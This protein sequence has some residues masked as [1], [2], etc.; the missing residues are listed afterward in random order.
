VEK[1]KIFHFHNG[2]GGGV[3]SVIRNLLLYRQ[4]TEIENHVIYTINKEQVFLY[5]KPMLQ[6]ATSEQIFYYSPQWNFYYTCRQLAK[7]IPDDKAVI[8]AHDW[9]ELGMVSNLGLRNPLIHFVHGAYEYYYNLARLHCNHVDQFLCVS[10]H[11]SAL[12]K[13]RLPNL[14]HRIFTTLAP[15]PAIGQS[16]S[17]FNSLRCCY[18][19]RDLTDPN[20]QFSLLPH[21][22][23]LFGSITG[24][25]IEWFVAGGG[26]TQDQ[27]YQYWN[28]STHRRI[29]YFGKVDRTYLGSILAKTNIFIL[30]SLNE[31]LPISSIEAMLSGN[32]PIVG[33]WANT[34]DEYLT[35]QVNGFIADE[36]SYQTF[37]LS[38]VH[39]IQDKDRFEVMS[40]AAKTKATQLFNPE[41]N[42]KYI[43]GMIL[44]VSKN[45]KQKK[46]IKVY[47][48]RL[49]HPLIPNFITHLLRTII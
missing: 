21:I 45:V 49:D 39:L 30:P 47:G 33:S 16:S 2:T 23:E 27:F 29:H 15:V 44:Q 12:L 4:D 24:K 18:F 20:K 32:V 22:D 26:M 3:L 41:I 31:G 8:V 13:V 38:M 14:A 34:A 17:C 46:P 42:T 35:D 11:I 40:H 36:Y 6:N 10:K 19:V 7:L 48:S 5:E 28:P 37:A 25:E 43:E 9:L 1:V